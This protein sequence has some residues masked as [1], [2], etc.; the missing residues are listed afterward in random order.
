MVTCISGSKCVTRLIKILCDLLRRTERDR[1]RGGEPGEREWEKERRYSRT[2]MKKRTKEEEVDRGRM[3][4]E[5]GK[6]KDAASDEG[7]GGGGGKTEVREGA[8]TLCGCVEFDSRSKYS[9]RDEIS[10]RP[11]PCGRS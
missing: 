2:T 10:R 9:I 1:E 8:V 7:R 11:S 4:R 3:G 6:V 5:R